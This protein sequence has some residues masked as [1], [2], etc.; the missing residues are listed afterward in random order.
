MMHALDK[1]FHTI[2]TNEAFK[3]LGS[4]PNG[5]T[6]L[7]ATDRLK[8]FGSNSLPQ[9]KRE[10]RRGIPDPQRFKNF[11]GRGPDP[12]DRRSNARASAGNVAAFP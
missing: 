11:P 2:S 10:P 5:L 9:P 4:S 6:A 3:K 1:S 12:C 7:E 8:Q